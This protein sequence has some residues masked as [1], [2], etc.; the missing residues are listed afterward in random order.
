MSESIEHHDQ[1]TPTSPKATNPPETPIARIQREIIKFTAE[2]EAAQRKGNAQ[3]QAALAAPEEED[4]PQINPY[5]TL[6]QTLGTVHA[7]AL[8]I[9][10]AAYFGSKALSED[11]SGGHLKSEKLARITV[12]KEK[13]PDDLDRLITQVYETGKVPQERNPNIVDEQKKELEALER[14]TEDLH[15]KAN[16][17]SEQMDGLTDEASRFRGIVAATLLALKN[18]PSD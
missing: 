13:G 7:A 5:A 11:L 15:A 9:I 18:Q 6:F 12:P 17:A 16:T 2:Q 8:L 10:F 3:L 4:S 1:D 14:M